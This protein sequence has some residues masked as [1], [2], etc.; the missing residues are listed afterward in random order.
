LIV[1]CTFN[2]IFIEPRSYKS[3]FRCEAKNLSG[4][5]V[6]KGKREGLHIDKKSSGE[7][8][9]KSKREGLYIDKQGK[10]RSFEPKKL[11]RKPCNKKL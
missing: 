4:E 8:V 2:Y 7:A 1:D 6:G 11:S 9:G 5:A 3:G 10:W